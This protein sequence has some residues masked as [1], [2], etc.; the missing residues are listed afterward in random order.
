MREIQLKE[1][2]RV[3]DPHKLS[4]EVILELGKELDTKELL[5]VET[6]YF[7]ASGEAYYNVHIY[8]GNDK[9]EKGKKFARFRKVWHTVEKNGEKE[10]KFTLEPIPEFEIVKEYEAEYIVNE[11]IKLSNKK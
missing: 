1:K 3:L 5:H 8:N 2:R 7:T 9:K 10:N 11:Y 6:I 4:N